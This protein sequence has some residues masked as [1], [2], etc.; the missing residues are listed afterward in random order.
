M[1]KKKHVYF[2]GA[3]KLNHEP[4]VVYVPRVS[5]AKEIKKL[6]LDFM[7]DELTVDK[8]ITTVW[9][10]KSQFDNRDTLY[11]KAWRKIIPLI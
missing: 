5:W 7:I 8:I 2:V 3:R 11:R 4:T 6:A 1:S 9:K 10:S